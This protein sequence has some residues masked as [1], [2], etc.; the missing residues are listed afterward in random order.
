MKTE[1]TANLESQGQESLPAD[2]LLEGIEA[3][4][5]LQRENME[6]RKKQCNKAR[7]WLM[8]HS[9]GKGSEPWIQNLIQGCGLEEYYVI[10]SGHDFWK[11]TN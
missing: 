1:K 4:L 9:A 2:A 8:R 7:N 6:W 10:L 5:D 11:S 3:A